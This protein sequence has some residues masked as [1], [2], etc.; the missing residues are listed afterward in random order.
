M[1]KVGGYMTISIE[2]MDHMQMD[3]L[4]EIGNIG[5]GNAMT[6]LA[7]MLNKKVDMSVPKVEILE[8][9]EVVELL[10]G[11]EVLVCG[12]YFRF[13]GD[14]A[15]NI[16]FMFSLPSAKL[17]T[18]LLML[19]EDNYTQNTEALDDIEKSALQEIGNILSGAY[20]SS[21]TMLT[22]LNMKLSIPSL[23][24]DMAGAILSV[25]IIQY[26]QVGD[27]VLLIE[28]EFHQE[29]KDIKGFFFL[30]PDL[31]FYEILLKSLGVLDNGSNN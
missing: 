12:I 4:K 5:A 16:M 29:D 11:P 1:V 15:G 14:M 22:G 21:L 30:I 25:P 20:I 17:L 26:G 7:Q 2:N 23:A 9:K 24:I 31:E 18:N 8:F 19:K 6:A 27:K 3:V 10:G 28:T 13:D